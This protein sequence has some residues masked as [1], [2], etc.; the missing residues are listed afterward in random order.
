MYY[1]FLELFNFNFAFHAIV[2]II[3]LGAFTALYSV[4]S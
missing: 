2:T 3:M 1:A 4:V